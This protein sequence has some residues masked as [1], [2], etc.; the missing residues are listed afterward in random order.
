MT[1][2]LVLLFLITCLGIDAYKQYKLRHASDVMYS[3]EIG[4]SMADGGE[5][6]KKEEKKS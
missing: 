3:P 5:K 6:I 2:I 1:V 4:L